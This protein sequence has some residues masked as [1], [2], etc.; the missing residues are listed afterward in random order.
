V[1]IK[2][3]S[4]HCCIGGNEEAD[5]LAKEGEGK[6][7]EDASVTYDETKVFIKAQQ[8]VK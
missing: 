4:A 8:K 5:A 6:T 1:V 7:Q 3:V 2:W